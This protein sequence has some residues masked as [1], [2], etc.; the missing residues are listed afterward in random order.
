MNSSNSHGNNDDAFDWAEIVD[1]R[2]KEQYNQRAEKYK[3]VSEAMK[4]VAEEKLEAQISSCLLDNIKSDAE[5]YTIK[6]LPQ[7]FYILP[8]ALSA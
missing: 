4:N 8:N 7:G 1:L 6:G 3:S 5:I 2:N